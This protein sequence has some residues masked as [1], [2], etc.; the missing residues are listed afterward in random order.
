MD[1]L[2]SVDLNINFPSLPDW[3]SDI[4]GGLLGGLTDFLINDILKPFINQALTGLTIDVY[5]ID[6]FFIPLGPGFEIRVVSVETVGINPAGNTLLAA[7]GIPSIAS[8][9]N[10]DATSTGKAII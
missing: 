5:T 10:I 2:N 1:G 4:I 3:I 9:S 7:Y 6:P 8:P